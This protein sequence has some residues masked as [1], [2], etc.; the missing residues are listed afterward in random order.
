MTTDSINNT[1]AKNPVSSLS[2][3]WAKLGLFTR[4]FIIASTLALAGS[5]TAL[6]LKVSVGLLVLGA[7]TILLGAVPAFNTEKFTASK[8]ES[9]DSNPCKLTKAGIIILVVSLVLG[10]CSLAFGIVMCIGAKDEE[11]IYTYD[12]TSTENV[13]SPGADKSCAV[14]VSPENAGMYTLKIKGAHLDGITTEKGNK[15]YP[16]PNTDEDGECY[17]VFL[18]INTAYSFSLHSTDASFSIELEKTS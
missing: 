18:V 2:R 11:L 7:L 8:S 3:I 1:K 17:S 12:F 15:I 14:E 4:C 13:F 6:I 9:S 10:I 5:V 16:T